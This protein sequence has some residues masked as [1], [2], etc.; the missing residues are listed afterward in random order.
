M[1]YAFSNTLRNADR[2]FVARVEQENGESVGEFPHEIRGADEL[3]YL[4]RESG[5]DS[6]LEHGGAFGDIGPEEAEGEVV[7]VPDSAPGLSEEKVKESF[8]PEH[9]RGRIM[10]GHAQPS[11][12][13]VP[14]SLPLAGFH[15]VEV[16]R[17]WHDRPGH[18]R[19]RSV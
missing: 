19:L 11:F 8:V 2:V 17:T 7:P 6:S 16:R 5:L 15:A 14:N 4:R 18:A 3:G 1:P 12:L 13:P 10:K 9:T